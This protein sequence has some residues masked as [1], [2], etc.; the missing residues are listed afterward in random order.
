MIERNVLLYF[1]GRK[2]RSGFTSLRRDR[3]GNIALTF[4]V[5]T[6]LIMIS[7]GAG[8][9]LMRAYGDQQKLTE[10]A[11]LT[12]QFATRP[13]VILTASTNYAGTGSLGSFN[14]T[15]NGYLTTELHTQFPSTAPAYNATGQ[16]TGAVNTQSSVALSSRVPTN[17]MRIVGFTTIPIAAS[18]TCFP[19]TASTLPQVNNNSILIQEKFTNTLGSG[20][21]YIEPSG[22]QGTVNGTAGNIP[23][24]NSFPSNPGFTGSDGSQWYIMGY[25]L[26]TDTV[27][28]INAVIPNSGTAA[29]LDCDNGAGSAGNSSISTQIYL[30]AGN[31]ELRY[32]Y[33]GRIDYPNYDPVYLCGSSVNDL[34]WANDNTT[35]ASWVGSAV[36]GS[37]RSNQINVYLDAPN[38]HTGQPPTHRTLDGQTLAGSNLIDECLYSPPSGIGLNDNALWVQRSVRIYV[39]T[40][41]YYWLTFAAD[42]HSDS[43]GGQVSDIVLCQGTCSGTVQDNFPSVSYNPYYP[44]GSFN[45]AVSTLLPDWLNPNGYNKGLFN[46][47][48]ESPVNPQNTGHDTYQYQTAGG[49]IT[50][51]TRGVLNYST[52]TFGTSASGWPSASAAAGW[53]TAVSPAVTP[54]A[55]GWAIAPQV[56]IVYGSEVSGTTYTGFAASGSQYAE[57]GLA[58]FPP[59]TGP[60]SILISRPFLLVPGYYNLSYQ[61]VTDEVL[62]YTGM[63]CGSTPAA[64]GASTGNTSTGTLRYSSIQATVPVNINYVGVFM[65]NAQLVSTPNMMGT[66]GA[67]TTYSNPDSTLADTPPVRATSTTAT[68]PPDAISLT[69]YQVSTTSA[70]LDFCAYSPTWFARSVNFSITKPGYYWLSFSSRMTDANAIGT[71]GGIDAIT[72]S[73][74]GSLAMTSPPKPY[75]A[76]P[77]GAPQPGSQLAAADGSGDFYIIA[78]PLTFPAAPQ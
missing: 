45:T 70:L 20:T 49:T 33:A 76:V 37:T 77:V 34:S 22:A 36:A 35:S 9:D 17:F 3:R 11:A 63:D 40:P 6:I 71:G 50:S 41:G 23:Q 59:Y 75:V 29:E 4:A 52:G 54:S 62:N 74:L 56:A 57:I 51:T 44:G 38:A 53:P 5:S 14:S 46:E 26:E 10:V 25:C 60:S 7:V 32:Y 78:D 27:G 31:F 13:S 12:C 2:L 67:T 21:H 28:S 69:N 47:S 72:L 18:A 39:N 30:E 58:P 68:V 19:T 48:F 55:A 43:F 42:G 64:A 24:N 15:V 16:F 1:I 61:Y 66:Y 65:S 8:M 73:A